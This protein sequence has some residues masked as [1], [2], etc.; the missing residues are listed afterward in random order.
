M[1]IGH[2]KAT[3]AQFGKLLTRTVSCELTPE[4]RIIISVLTQAWSDANN[5][6]RDAIKFFVDGRG[7]L[8]AE[9]IGIDKDFLKETF[10][11][12]HQLSYLAV[13]FENDR[14]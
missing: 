4:V 11:K 5:G 8:F 2:E 6:H 13:D 12:H 14:A 1:K 3:G 9:T 10:M 7:G